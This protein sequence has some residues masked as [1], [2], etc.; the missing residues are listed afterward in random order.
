[1][2]DAPCAQRAIIPRTVVETRLSKAVSCFHSSFGG[3]REH[4]CRR[5]S[6][7]LEANC[8]W[9]GFFCFGSWHGLLLLASSRL[10]IQ[11]QRQHQKRPKQVAPVGTG[12]LMVVPDFEKRIAFD[13][14]FGEKRAVEQRLLRLS[15]PCG[16]QP[17]RQWHAEAVFRI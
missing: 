6:P 14:A 12:G 2:F 9:R 5:L 1:M 15:A 7:E 11:K 16:A 13:K 4:S 10:F 17:C 8:R 3:Y